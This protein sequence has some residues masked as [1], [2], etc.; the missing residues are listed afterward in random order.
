MQASFAKLKTG[1]WGVRIVGS[2]AVMAGSPVTV[3]T[4]AGERKTITLGQRVWEGDG[5][6]LW[7]CAAEARRASSGYGGS[8][9]RRTGCSCGSVEG[10]VKSSDCWTCR[11]DAE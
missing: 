1:A 2:A 11:H 9:Y 7:A 3:T 8:G 4:R 6:T 10:M 5:V